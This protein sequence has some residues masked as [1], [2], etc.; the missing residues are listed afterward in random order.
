MLSFVEH[1]KNQSKMPQSVRLCETD[2]F[3]I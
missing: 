1:S 3:L 2:H